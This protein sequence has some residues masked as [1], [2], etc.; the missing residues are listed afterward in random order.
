MDSKE[1]LLFNSL[2]CEEADGISLLENCEHEYC[3]EGYCE[4]CGMEMGSKIDFDTGYSENHLKGKNSSAQSYSTEI[5]KLDSIS[6]ELKKMVI[7]KLTKDTSSNRESGRAFNIFCAVYVA[8]AETGEMK[9]DSIVKSLK[10][11]GRSVNK[12]LRAIS[13]TGPKTIKD[14]KGGVLVIPVVSI[15]PLDCV[16]EICKEIDNN[17][18]DDE[19][20]TL[21]EHI[22]AIKAMIS[23]VIKKKPSLLNDRPTY[24]AAGFI[25]FYCQRNDLNVQDINVHAK[26]SSP[27]LNQY[28]SR[29]KKQYAMF[30]E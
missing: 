5:D 18:E 11:N 22:D 23:K 9:P 13:G 15:S 10:M 3:T 6:D 17:K 19:Q 28:S 2:Y 1:S 29:A 4:T 26:M 21:K 24:V 20:D 27:T 12:S 16:S 30:V 25:K 14:D 8:G 7:N